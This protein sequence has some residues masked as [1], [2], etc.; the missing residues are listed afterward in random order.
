M[1]DKERGLLRLKAQSSG[2][3]YGA[4]WCFTHSCQLPC[5]ICDDFAALW[6]RS[7][8]AGKCSDCRHDTLLDT[9]TQEDIAELSEQG[10]KLVGCDYC[11]CRQVRKVV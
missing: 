2:E 6:R 8:D 5:R 3:T 1:T 10:Y 4:T 11:G 9:A 7:V